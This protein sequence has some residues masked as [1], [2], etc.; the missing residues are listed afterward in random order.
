MYLCKLCMYVDRASTYVCMY[1][2]CMRSIRSSRD[3]QTNKQT[4][5]VGC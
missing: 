5:V 1:V 2:V 4:I 3:G